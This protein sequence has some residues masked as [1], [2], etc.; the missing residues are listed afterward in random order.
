MKSMAKKS[1]LT[2]T[3]ISFI[4]KVSHRSMRFI[5]VLIPFRLFDWIHAASRMDVAGMKFAT[6]LSPTCSLH[7]AL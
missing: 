5:H 4:E 3:E 7:G 6:P 2:K 1:A